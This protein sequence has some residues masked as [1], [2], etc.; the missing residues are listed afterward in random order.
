M[1][2]TAK[3]STLVHHTTWHTIR[4]EDSSVVLLLLVYGIVFASFVAVLFRGAIIILVQPVSYRPFLATACYSWFN[5]SLILPFSQRPVTCCGVCR[6][7]VDV[8]RSPST[9]TPPSL[10]LR[11]SSR[12]KHTE[13][14]C[15]VGILCT[16]GS[17]VVSAYCTWYISK[18]RGH[19][20]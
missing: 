8:C 9:A 1:R 17:I 18:D 14:Y 12:G 3:A 11:M 20:V 16:I 13:I 10:S 6:V 19:A 15:I 5:L 2:L 4:S 7:C